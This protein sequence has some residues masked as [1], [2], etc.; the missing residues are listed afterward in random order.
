MLGDLA[1]CHDAGRAFGVEEEFLLVDPA[2]GRTAPGA[3]EVLRLAGSQPAAA[4]DAAPDAAL[5]TELLAT[6]VEAATGRC[7]SLDDLTTQ[8]AHARRQLNAAAT[9]AGRWLVPSGTAVLGG[10][11]ATTPHERFTGIVDTYAGV[12]REYQTCGCHVHVQVPELET[13]VA[14][15]NHLR[16]WLPT[17]LAL[18]A[19][20]PFHQGHDTG[21]ASWRMIEQARFPGSGVPPWFGSASAYTAQV[22]RLVEQ[23]ILVDDAMTFW[24]ARPSPHLPTVE[25][26]VADTAIDVPGAVLQAA[27]SRALV[28]TALTE[29]ERGRPAPRVDAQ[30]ASAAVWSAARYGLAGHGV[31]P[32]LATRVPAT[33]LLDELLAWVTPALDEAGDRTAVHDLVDG[34][35]RTGTGAQRQRA[36]TPTDPFHVVRYL[37][38]GV[39]DDRS[40]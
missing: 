10:E 12:V 33:A 19:N 3:A 28:A 17:L 15:V 25:L 16:P 2:T 4:P 29:L 20:S 1:P 14:V 6:Q 9:A 11:T 38:Q 30:V 23:G 7:L 22:D 32:V 18:S 40:Y 21:Y 36:V 27:L 39:T 13:A 34:V 24:L 5:Q 37:A 31:H 26:R 35:L 8:L